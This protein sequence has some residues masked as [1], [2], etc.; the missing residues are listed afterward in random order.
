MTSNLG[1]ELILDKRDYKEIK[2]EIHELLY[3]NFKPEFL[4]R[5]DEIITFKPLNS[6]TI[7]EITLI[8]I[9]KLSKLLKPSKISLDITKD[10]ISKLAELGYNPALGARPLKRVI[11]QE[12]QDKLSILIL[13]GKLLPNT[14]IKIDYREDKFI[15]E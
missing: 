9:K 12:I 11:Q 15:F 2:R 3:K 1:S 6:E 7:K 10:A 13:E 14:T 5:I 8:E 4:N